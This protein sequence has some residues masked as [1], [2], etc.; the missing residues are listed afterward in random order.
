MKDELRKKIYRYGSF[1]NFGFAFNGLV[2]PRVSMWLMSGSRNIITG[3]LPRTFFAFFWGAVGLFGWGYY[4]VS[5]DP[6][7]NQDIIWMGC[8]AKVII[9]IT[10]TLLYF[11]RLITTFAFLGGLGDFIW[12]ILFLAALRKEKKE[13]NN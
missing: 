3:I 4:L 2:M 7:K 11:H 9:F 1:W 12:T 8:F 5:R 13:E 6:D 10:F